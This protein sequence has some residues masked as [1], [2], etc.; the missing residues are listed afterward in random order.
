MLS[1]FIGGACTVAG[2]PV[3][4]PGASTLP[5]PA[6]DLAGLAWLPDGSLVSAKTEDDEDPGAPHRL[7]RLASGASVFQAVPVAVDR[8]CG[9]DEYF[10][11]RP[12]ADGRIAAVRV[13]ID[14]DDAT[15]SEWTTVVVFDDGRASIVADFDTLDRDGAV[16]PVVFS[17]APGLREGIASVFG[18]I[19]SGLVW[20]EDGA[21]RP[22]EV[23]VGQGAQ[24]FALGATLSVGGSECETTGQARDPT[25]S[26]DGSRIAFLASPSSVGV[27]ATERLEQPYEVY[28]MDAEKRVPVAVL[29]GVRSPRGLEWSPDGTELLLTGSVDGQGAGTWTVDPEDGRLTRLAPVG[30][31]WVTWSPDGD[32]IAG[33]Y[34]RLAPDSTDPRPVE[35]KLMIVPVP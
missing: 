16:G 1:L 33:I 27:P 28:V 4:V 11:P 5:V 14:P 8:R 12:V 3:T 2:S 10:E 29:P 31:D 32:A 13:C 24:R 34:T 30:F 25:W 7:Y 19:C 22:V 9:E 17:F 20:I 18:G 15:I 21:V 26:P 6:Q 35:A 23:E